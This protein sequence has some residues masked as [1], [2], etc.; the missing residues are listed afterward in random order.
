MQSQ[1]LEM[2]DGYREINIRRSCSFLCI[3]SCRQLLCNARVA[4]T[5]ALQQK[6]DA[7]CALTGPSPVTQQSVGRHISK[8]GLA[9]TVDV[10][11]LHSSALMVTTV[12]EK[13][14]PVRT[15][16]DASIKDK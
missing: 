5:E 7:R 9:L 15:T 6:D 14:E 11:F 10:A 8:P 13:D 16:M 3:R 1:S 12:P 4:L 2:Q